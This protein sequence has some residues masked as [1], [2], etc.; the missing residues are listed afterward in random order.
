MAKTFR[1]D[2]RALRR[3][4]ARGLDLSGFFGAPVSLSDRSAFEAPISLRGRA[5]PAAYVR[6][7]AF[8]SLGNVR[9]NNVEIGRYASIADGA[10]VSAHNHPVAWL[11]VSR[12]GFE[13]D[14]YGWPGLIRPEIAEEVRRIAHPFEEGERRTVVGNDV[15]IGHGAFIK[16]GVRIGNGAI[17]GA[18]AVVTRDV[19]PFSIV[20]GAPARLLKRRFPEKVIERIER[21][22]WWEY[23]LYD[24]YSADF[25]DPERALD[26]L[27]ALLG[28]GKIAPYL[29]QVYSSAEV[30]ELCSDA[31]IGA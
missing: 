15:W 16:A 14:L 19:E 1:V 31:A 4:R 9:L 2:D 7:G 10:V 26:V 3:L 27:E 17:V 22:Q 12:M 13:S 6:I 29:A 20:G 24:F 5:G 25:S 23:C 8:S 11:T 18:L 21:L 28:A 30:S